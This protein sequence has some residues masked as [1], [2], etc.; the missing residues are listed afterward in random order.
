MPSAGSPNRN[1]PA[2]GSVLTSINEEKTLGANT[3]TITDQTF[4][5]AIAGDRVVIVDFWAEWCGPCKMVE[6][7]LDEIAAEYPEKLTVAKLNIDENPQS[8]ANYGV[9]GIP[10]MIVFADGAKAKTIVGAR[11]KHQMLKELEPFLS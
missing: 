1:E 7:I 6:P 8:A 2:P 5:S 11:P 10:T 3:I 4:E 9:M